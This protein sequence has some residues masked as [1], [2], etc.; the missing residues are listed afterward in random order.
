MTHELQK[1]G[2]T[3]GIVFGL[4]GAIFCLR[5]REYFLYILI[6]SALFLICAF[7]APV[8]L[9]P[10]H[11]LWMTFAMAMGWV[12]TRVILCILFYLVVTPTGL[13]A[14]L[15][16]KAFLDI[17]FDKTAASYWIPKSSEK[18]SYENQY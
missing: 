10:V 8:C 5:G 11:K 3:L 14:R 18:S 2:I 9:K 7:C 4:F 6:L 13:V 16:G 12:M 17:K 1:F 15:F